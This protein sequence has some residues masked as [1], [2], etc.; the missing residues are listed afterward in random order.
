MAGLRRLAAGWNDAPTLICD[1]T[2]DPELLQAIWPKLECEVAQWEQLPRPD[3]VRV[4][5]CVDKA[6]SKY[7][8]AVEG[9]GEQLKARQA[10]A[11]RAYAA[12][13]TLSTV[14]YRGAD[15]GV[16]VYKST[17]EFIEKNCFVPPWLKLCHHGDITGTNALQKV[18]ALF[19]IGRPLAAAEA[20]TRQT[21]ALFGEYI[22]RREYRARAKAGRIPTVLDSSGNNTI[23]VDVWEHPDPRA[24]RVRRQV[25]EAA[26]V[27]AIGRARA[28]LRKADEPLDIHLWTDLPLPE[29]GP[30]EPM[31]WSELDA[32]LDGQMLAAEG[33]WLESTA[34]AGQ[35]YPDEFSA[36]AVKKARQRGQ[37]R[38]ARKKKAR[39][40]ALAAVE[41]RLSLKYP[42][43]SRFPHACRTCD[44]SLQS[45]FYLL[46]I[47]SVAR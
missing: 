18:R 40:R 32:G 8:V 2:G 30:V 6:L 4:F 9:E 5:Q 37:A 14:R 38:S 12:V 33:V 44:M 45:D 46:T 29:L 39:A 1:A 34:D 41:E 24:E 17:R 20:I 11:K 25:T 3:S 43:T 27:Q 28:G 21:E 22:S 47:S 26:L 42:D 13:L 35:A 23:L 31:L 10:A 19:V 15:V 16:I 7:M 36:H